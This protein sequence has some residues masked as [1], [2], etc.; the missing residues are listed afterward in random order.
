MD[1]RLA[2]ESPEYAQ[3]LAR[4]GAHGPQRRHLRM[5]RHDEQLRVGDNAASRTIATILRHD[6]KVTSYKLAL[7][8][9]INDVVLSFPD[10]GTHDQPVAIP[11]RVLAEYWLAYYWPSSTR[12]TRSLRVRIRCGTACSPTTW[13]FGRRWPLYGRHG[14]RLSARPSDPPTASFSSTNSG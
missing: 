7:I 9:A 5:E 8:R 12:G 11:L 6:A 2:Q 10:A 13:R 4:P 1:W 14:K 3:S